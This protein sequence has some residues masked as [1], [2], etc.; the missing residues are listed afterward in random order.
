MFRA[1]K[2]RL[3][4]G[5]NQA[6]E[7][8][9]ALETHRHLYNACLAERKAAFETEKRSV[10]YTEQSAWFTQQRSS[11]PWFA[12]LNFSSAQATMRNLDKAFQAFFRRVKAGEKEPGYPRFKG[13]DRFDSFTYPSIGDGARVVGNKLRLQHVGLVRINLH[14]EI[15][16][17]IKTINIKREIDKWYV[18][19]ACELPDVPLA[20][21]EKPHV[22]LDVG[23]E[24]FI[25]ASDA[26]HKPPLQPLKANLKKLRIEQRS[27]SRK[28]KGS[29]CRRKQRRTVACLHR[30]VANTRKDAHHKIAV[31]LVNRYGGFAVEGLNIQGMVKNHRL[32]R[33]VS[34]AGWSQFLTILKHKAEGAG[35]QYTEVDARYTSQTCPACSVV[36]KKTLSERTHACECGYT[37]HRDHAAAQVIFA[38]GMLAGTQPE[39]LNVGVG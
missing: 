17:E 3:E 21:S 28:V 15:E 22:G 12:R 29:N 35:I 34:D 10:K 5:V 38:R 7:L 13:R 32:A 19:V 23:L 9:I 20:A 30:T 33:A 6:R 31:G 1:Y 26:E 24:R 2:F 18:T 11:N 4:P 8:G 27:L 37:T 16:G 25:T 39:R 14:R 36:V